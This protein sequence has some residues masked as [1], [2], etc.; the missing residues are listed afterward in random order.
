MAI[1]IAEI[2]HRLN[3]FSSE[4]DACFVHSEW[5]KMSEILSARQSFLEQVLHPVTD[6]EQK[7]VLTT[8][9][10]TL[11]AEDSLSLSKIQAQQQKLLA[12]H[13]LMDQ[14]IRAVKAYSGK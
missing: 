13:T 5:D 11:L 10:N 9:A 2:N 1:N 12:L 8:L 7:A 6:N 3:A 14:G 4:I